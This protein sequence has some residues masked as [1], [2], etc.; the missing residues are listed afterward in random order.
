MH[1][2]YQEQHRCN[3]L[4]RLEIP[5]GNLSLILPLFILILVLWKGRKTGGGA[6]IKIV[7]LYSG[8]PTT[9]VATTQK[10]LLHKPQ[11]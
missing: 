6:L 10:A 4:T 11:V 3:F 8:G 9:L 7:K 2:F 5:E 1:V